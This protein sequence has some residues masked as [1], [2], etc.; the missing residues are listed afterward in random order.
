MLQKS[1]RVVSPQEVQVKATGPTDRRRL[2]S[3]LVV[4]G[5]W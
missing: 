2:G 4:A 5:S 1:A 3:G